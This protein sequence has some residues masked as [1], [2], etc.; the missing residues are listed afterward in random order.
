MEFIQNKDAPEA[1]NVFHCTDNPEWKLRPI[2]IE[3]SEYA[4]MRKPLGALWATPTDA[5]WGWPEWC[6]AEDFYCKPYRVHLTLDASRIYVIDS[7]TDLLNMP[8]IE[9]TDLPFLTRPDFAAL[10]TDGC[11]AIWLTEQGQAATRWTLPYNLYG[12]DCECVAIIDD[13]CI[14][15]WYHTGENKDERSGKT[16]HD[17]SDQ[18]AQDP[19]RPQGG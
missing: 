8:W 19:V 9:E 12:W 1:L 7:E 17:L 15:N 16:G 2:V 11:A 3:H 18:S 13:D 10:L 5:T 6:E 14:L 4:W